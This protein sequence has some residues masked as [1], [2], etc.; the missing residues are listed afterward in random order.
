MGGWGSLIKDSIFGEG[1]ATGTVPHNGGGVN[2]TINWL[3]PKLDDGSTKPRSRNSD[4]LTLVTRRER[5]TYAEWSGEMAS[6]GHEDGVI[7]K[8]TRL[9]DCTNGVGFAC[10]TTQYLGAC[11]NVPASEVKD[12]MVL[13]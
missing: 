5:T 10:C 4:H 2:A 1:I 13:C 9:I 3:D 11:S 6:V 8:R 12:N 7:L